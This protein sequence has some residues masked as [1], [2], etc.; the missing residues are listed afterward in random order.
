MLSIAFL[1]PIFDDWWDRTNIAAGKTIRDI[2]FITMA[3][4]I[5]TWPILVYNFSLLSIVAP[6]SNILVLWTLP[7][8]ITSGILAIA[9]SWF[10]PFLGLVWFLP[11]KLLIDYIIF[12]ARALSAIPFAYIEINSPGF[13]WLALYYLGLAILIRKIRKK[14]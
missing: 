9:I 1:Y 10:L 12:I 13:I 7:F 4:Q 6:L 11:L 8:I 2:F 14:I 5:F 3:V